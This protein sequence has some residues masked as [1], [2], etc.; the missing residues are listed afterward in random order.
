MWSQSDVTGI[1]RFAG[2]SKINFER[3]KS[4]PGN[5]PE[6]P[7]E[8]PALPT[9]KSSKSVFAVKPMVS[10]RGSLMPQQRLAGNLNAALTL[11]ARAVPAP[12]RR[13]FMLAWRVLLQ[14]KQKQ[15]AHACCI[16][17]HEWAQ[18]WHR[19]EE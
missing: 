1:T 12:R 17:T 4:R 6:R 2:V 16:L 7:A 14:T 9:R 15:R 13:A 3:K 19:H 10:D 8:P 18:D 5:F 11:T